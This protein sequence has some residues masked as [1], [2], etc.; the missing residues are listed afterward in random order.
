[1]LI[2]SV[3]TV[4]IDN[5]NGVVNIS[6][7]G[8]IAQYQ[9]ALR[10]VRYEN[11]NDK[12]P[13]LSNRTI[14][15]VINDGTYNS[16]PVS[17][18]IQITGVNDPPVVQNDTYGGVLEGGNLVVNTANG[19]LDND[20]DLDG[21]VAMTA[22][23]VDDVQ[24][25][26]LTLNPNGSFTYMHN[27]TNNLVDGFT[28]RAFDGQANSVL[29]TVTITIVGANDPPELSGIETTVLTY[30]ED[31]PSRQITATIVVYDEDNLNLQYRDFSLRNLL[32]AFQGF[33]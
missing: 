23:L 28:Y 3:F 20:E 13:S 15:F 1:M 8:T 17:R 33:N 12:N 6:G 9:S 10:T 16:T 5:A 26:S 18:V 24:F 11:I 30:N 19:V 22:T 2:S 4:N 25:G 31:D 14:Q 32:V 29:A 21:P 27:G 7:D